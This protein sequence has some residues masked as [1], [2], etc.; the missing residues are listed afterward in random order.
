M[1]WLAIVGLTVLVI[2]ILHR[3]LDDSKEKIQDLE[4]RLKASFEAARFI[5]ESYDNQ[6]KELRARIAELEN[7]PVPSGI[8]SW[9]FDIRMNDI[10]DDWSRCF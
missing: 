9:E 8:P 6:I 2:C 5:S 3:L 1:N 4:R 7:P 10:P